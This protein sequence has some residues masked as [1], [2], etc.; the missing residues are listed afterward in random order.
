MT[1][2]ADPRLLLLAAGLSLVTT[3]ALIPLVKRVAFS[4]GYVSRPRDDR[5]ISA[6]QPKALFGGVAILA[7]FWIALLVTTSGLT[8]WH[9]RILLAGNIAFGLIGFLDDLLEFRP[10][11]KVL[12][13][14]V[15]SLLPIAF[16]L[17]IPGLNPVA[18]QLIAMAWIVVVVNAVNLLDNMDGLAS[19]VAAIAASVLAFQGMQS[20]NVP[21]VLAAI[22][23]AGSCVGFLLHNFPPS[24]I[25]MGDTGSHFLGY[26]LAVLT[27]LDVAKSRTTILTAIA[28]PALVLLVPIF[29][30]ALVALSRFAHGRPVTAGAADHSSHR[31]VSLGLTERQTAVL[32]YALSFGGGLASLAL[33]RFSLALMSVCMLLLL[34]T[35]YY[36]GNFLSRVPV[37]ARTAEGVAAA[38]SRRLAVFN[39]FIP[40][41][42]PLLDLLAD[43]CV[44]VGA[45][46]AA[47]LLRF[48]GHLDDANLRL[49]SW[50]L[51]IVLASRLVFFQI[52]GLYRRVWGHFSVSDVLSIGKAVLGSSAT[53]VTIIAIGFKFYGFSRAVVII[54]AALTFGLVVMGHASLSVFS[55]L[56]RGRRG[57]VRTLIVGA[58]DLG[59]A[60]ARLLR[61]D[62]DGARLILGYLDDDQAKIGRRLQG[63][64]V[65][66]PIE[67]LEEIATRERA[68]EVVIAVSRLPE[69]RTTSIRAACDRLGVSVRRVSIE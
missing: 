55:E 54:D 5:W 57:A 40:Y 15:A 61:S 7:G 17:S 21:L 6:S 19:G 63:V 42:W 35:A 53:A 67:R 31:L 50:S 28:G 30:T 47:Y 11:T 4:L 43:I 27:L 65:D 39:A 44:I 51:P 52:L 13:Q 48:E 64:I 46:V 2:A 10:A 12:C 29:D 38:Q 62:P 14:V 45:H 66:G 36:F 20:G 18:G 8:T 33:S 1:L 69:E 24:S 25:F 34:V 60:A 23:L 26:T 49:L 68:D 59:S 9:W 58:G 37:Y 16:G 32:L 41:K 22:A 56:F 3:L